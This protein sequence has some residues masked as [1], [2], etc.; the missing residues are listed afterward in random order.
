MGLNVT[1]RTALRLALKRAFFSSGIGKRIERQAPM[2]PISYFLRHDTLTD[3]SFPSRIERT[4]QDHQVLPGADHSLGNSEDFESGRRPMSANEIW[5]HDRVSVRIA[6]ITCHLNISCQ[7]RTTLLER[8]QPHVFFIKIPSFRSFSSTFSSSM[9]VDLAT[10]D[11][12][13][14]P[15]IVGSTRP[16]GLVMRNSSRSQAFC[17]GKSKCEKVE[18]AYTRSISLS[19]NRNGGMKLFAWASMFG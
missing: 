10:E 9:R 8:L 14:L 19:A 18:T 1:R 12:A 17:V 13:R 15:S 6:K 5:R 11:S 16:P 7:C 3:R 4:P 2:P